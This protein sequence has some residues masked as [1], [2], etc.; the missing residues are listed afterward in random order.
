MTIINICAGILLAKIIE[1][2]FHEG[3]RFKWQRIRLGFKKLFRR[4]ERHK[5]AV[6]VSRSRKKTLEDYLP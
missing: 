3:Y 4:R 6:K 5:K 1:W 2:I